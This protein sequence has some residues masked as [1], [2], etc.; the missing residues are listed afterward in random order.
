M[1]V[2]DGVS[3]SIAGPTGS[4]RALDEVCLRLERGEA[5]ALM[6]ANGSGKSTLCRCLNGLL[7]PRKGSVTVDGLSTAHPGS[8]HEIRRLVGV[9]FQDPQGQLLTWSVE[10]EIAFGLENLGLP[11]EAIESAVET[12]LKR[13]NLEGF[14]ASHPLSLSGGQMAALALA[15]VMAMN[16]GYLVVDEPTSFLDRAGRR[17][18]RA[19]LM[20]IRRSGDVGVLWVTQ[21]PEEAA[22]FDRLVIMQNGRVVGDGKSDEL[23]C[24]VDDLRSWGLEPT[25]ATLL[26]RHLRKSGVTLDREHVV[27]ERLLDELDACSHGLTGSPRAG[28]SPSSPASTDGE[29]EDSSPG[30]DYGI[31]Q[32]GGAGSHASSPY[33]GL[34]RVGFSYPSGPEL[35]RDVTFEL[36]PGSGLGLVGPSGSG[37][38]TLLFLLSGV[39]EPTS[40][41][42][43]R[44]RGLPAGG[45]V[46]LA[47]QLPE[48]GFCS[49]TVLG[50]VGLGLDSLKISSAE[51]ERRVERSLYAVGL[52]ISKVGE[53]SPLSLSEGEKRKVSVASAIAREGA[54]LVL[55]EPTLALDGPSASR[56]G[57]AIRG[58]LERGGAAVIASHCGDILFRTTGALILLEGGRTEGPLAWSEA[59]G[60]PGGLGRLPEGQLPQL[61]FRWGKV[62]PRGFLSSLDGTAGWYARLAADRPWAGHKAL[63]GA[64]RGAG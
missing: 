50:E 52:D 19:E 26:S 25:P 58:H 28:A 56:I 49:S 10:E 1:I 32:P 21:F 51:I 45:Q 54:I 61:A 17:R 18:L 63:G 62:P 20:R 11:S 3:H 23:L 22:A 14:R 42:V 33:C 35:L 59:L 60:S 38:S 40:G 53:R 44:P 7:L 39:F 4:H 6:G 36:S 29:R 5:V 24:R 27:M 37:K 30:L 41:T 16:P 57:D 8:L 34:E 48:E 47:S 55:D 43:H 9:V 13:W 2:L 15:S 46:G 12:G 64:G 31:L